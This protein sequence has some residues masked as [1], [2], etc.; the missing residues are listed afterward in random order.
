M[1]RKGE[2]TYKRKD[3][4]WDARHA[5]GLTP[6]GKLRYSSC[7][8]QTCAE[9][10]RKADY[11]KALSLVCLSPIR[12]APDRRRF[13]SFCDD[14][15]QSTRGN[16]K[17]ST[18][19][20]YEA[21]LRNHIKPRLGD[22]S[23]LDI[24]TQT[25]ELFKH[26]L[27]TEN[28]LAPKSVKDILVILR[29]V[30]KFTA[31]RFPGTL[32]SIDFIY[33]REFRKE[34][35]VLSREEQRRFS[36]YLMEDMDRCKFGVLLALLTG[37]RIGELCALR[38]GSISLQSRIL[39]VTATVQRLP[40]PSGSSKTEL[41]IGDPKSETSARTIPLSDFAARLCLQVGPGHSTDFVLTGTEHCMEP[42]VLQYRIKKYT[43]AC[44]LKDVHFHTLRHTFATRCVEAG[45]EVKSL[46][47]ILGH[48]N[49]S[50]TMDRYVHPSM[51]LK[52]KNMEK[53]AAM[54][55]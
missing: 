31:K 43:D 4:R 25:V 50:I 45:F 32:P 8:G 23:P 16:V 53:L 42:R 51:E 27:L 37:L 22:C 36:D 40:D 11:A 19:A 33:P 2:N 9:A 1:P 3:G 29:T 28:G 39:R 47:E 24:T 15:L 6:S 17:L 52:R 48:A 34:M 54:G 18:F 5:K 21:V 44:G 26:D 30:L 38:W 46:S 35:R 12:D 10:K 41:V 7:Y 13:S 49:T 20:R 55:L 14:W